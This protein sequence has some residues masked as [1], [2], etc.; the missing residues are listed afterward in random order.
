[1]ITL[2]YYST[3]FVVNHCTSHVTCMLQTISLFQDRLQQIPCN[4]CISHVL[5]I[6]QI[7]NY[8]DH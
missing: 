2:A 3:K 8:T 7:N 1:M 5:K 4:F 6:L